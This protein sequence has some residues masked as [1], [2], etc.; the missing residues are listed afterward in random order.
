MNTLRQLVIEIHRRSLWQVLGIFLAASWGVIEVVDLLTEQVGLPDWTSNMALVLLLIGLP[1]VLGTAFVQEGMP[2]AENGGSAAG[3]EAGGVS[4]GDGVAAAGG[5]GAGAAAAVAGAPSTSSAPANLAAGTGS[6]DRPTTRPSQTQRLFTWRNAILGGIGAFTLLGFSLFVYFVMWTSGIGPV[7]N[8]VAQGIIDEGERVVLAEFDD[9]T[10][11]GLG[12]V[13]TEALRVDLAEA[14]VLDLVEDVDLAPVLER[15]QVEPGTALSAEVAREAAQREGIKAVIDC[16]VAT[17]GTGYIVTAA[18]R[19]ASDGRAIASFRV[20]ADGPDQIITSIDKLSQDIREKSGE[21]LRNIRSGEALAQVTTSSLDALRLYAEADRTF[22]RGDYRR[23]MELLEEAVELD[24]AFAMA[25]RRLGAVYNN[26]SIDQGRQVHAITQAYEHRDRLTELERYLA[27]AYYYSEVPQDRAA[28]IAAYQNVLSIDPDDQAALNNLANEYMDIESWDRAAEL[29]RRA[30]DGPGRSNTAFQNLQRAYIGSGRFADTE[31]LY[32]EYAAAYP[33]DANLPGFEFWVRFINGDM[34]AAVSAVES[35]ARDPAEPGF[36]R[37]SALQQMATVAYWEGRL[38]EG[39]RLM[40]ESER[41][42]GDVSPAFAWTQRNWTTFS[43]IS[44]GDPS[45]GL[46]HLRD[47][48]R[49]GAF[50]AIENLVSR[51]HFFTALNLGMSG[52]HDEAEA[53]LVE[54]ESLGD[55]LGDNDRLDIARGR[56]Y[57]DVAVGD[58]VGAMERMEDLLIERE[59]ATCWD[60]EVAWMAHVMGRHHQ[61]IELHE[62][63]LNG[64]FNFLELNGPYRQRSMFALGPLYEAVGDTANAIRAYQRIVDQWADADSRGMV[65]VRDAEARIAALGG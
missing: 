64:G 44:V 11:E 61:A 19:S 55:L 21:S 23:T 27:E 32:E 57:A 24:P 13:V 33:G 59:C 6:L 5:G 49:G 63:V 56:L 51:N 4:D 41:A 28:T 16:E 9:A 34:D 62:K 54:M 35:L 18:L 7:G 52:A 31:G 26:V 38:D 47:G 15:M 29:Y 37:A 3:G 45:W 60:A 1:I 48:L 40:R 14:S 22:D 17:A 10:G 36:V 43:E 50:E 12:A 65:R 30:I 20:A 2:R 39:R 53:V 42:G 58:T 8:L 46:E 25:W